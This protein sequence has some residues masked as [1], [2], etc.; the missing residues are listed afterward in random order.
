MNTP[1]AKTDAE[2]REQLSPEQFE[3]TRHGATERPFSGRYVHPGAD[4]IF[5]CVCCKA[6]LFDS[7]TQFDS[8]SG[9]PSFQDAID[10]G[11]V[12]T[13]TDASH[14]MTRTEI[15]CAHCDAHLG[16]LFDDGP[17]PNGLRYCVNSAALELDAQRK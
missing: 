14:G 11:S 13:L 2:W 12:R 3:V 16:H 10:A 5:R 7:G 15:R 8:G 4:G 9:W 17:G 1:A 6:P